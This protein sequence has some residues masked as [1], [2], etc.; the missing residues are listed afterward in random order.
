MSVIT[1]GPHPG[2]FV[3]WEVLRDYTRESLT[4]AAGAGKLQ[5]GTVLG[6]ITASGKYTP[7]SP[8]ATNGAQN[9]VAVLWGPAAA[10][11][12]DAPCTALVRG[13]ATLK[14]AGLILP[15]GI[16]EAQAAAAHSA[17]AALGL[18]SR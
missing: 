6:K 9:A 16:T 17:L 10:T 12:T 8:S 18:I 7:L 15:S 2:D 3:I 14:R 4:L 13:P 11:D 1:E 5:A